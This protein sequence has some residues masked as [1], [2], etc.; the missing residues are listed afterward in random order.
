MTE[1]K[2]ENLQNMLGDNFIGEEPI[3][4]VD[5]LNIVGE[6]VLS[7]PANFSAE[8]VAPIVDLVR[9]RPQEITEDWLIEASNKLRTVLL[10]IS[11]KPDPVAKQ[12][13]IDAGVKCTPDEIVFAYQQVSRSDIPNL[14]WLEIGNYAAGLVHL[15][16]LGNQKHTGHYWDL[17]ARVNKLESFDDLFNMLE[18]VLSCGIPTMKPS[19]I[20]ENI[21]EPLVW[22]DLIINPGKLKI[23]VGTNGFLVTFYPIKDKRDA[24]NRGAL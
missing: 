6:K 8:L 1:N 9:E 13:V 16:A 23:P 4:F 19:C 7:K 14:I 10:S 17:K 21:V 18:G 2:F 22:K 3:D 20:I 5:L 24:K 15:L 11:W 12:A